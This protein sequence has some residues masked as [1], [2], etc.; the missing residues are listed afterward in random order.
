LRRKTRG[1]ETT[2]RPYSGVLNDGI[3]TFTRDMSVIDANDAVEKICK[4][5]PIELA[6]RNFS[7]MD[8]HCSKACQ[9]IL[10]ETIKGQSTIRESRVE[11]R[12][13]EQIHQVVSVTSSPLISKNGESIG[14]VMVVRDETRLNDLEN[15]LRVRHQFHN[16]IG[17]KRK[18]AGDLQAAR[19]SC[20]D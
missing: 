4:I 6:G 1:S 9:N 11:C 17:K 20:P 18:D 15:E 3:I 16:I 7:E 2:L 12:Q 10:S 13:A 8:I 14:A 19:R 5:D